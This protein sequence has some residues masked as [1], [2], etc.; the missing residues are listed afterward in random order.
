MANQELQ[1]IRFTRSGQ[2]VHFVILALIF[3]C[4]GVGLYLVSLD[5]W[6]VSQEPLLK[7]SW[8]GLL[9]LPFVIACLW[10][11]VR[12]SKHAYLIFSPVGIEIFPFFKPSTNMNVLLWNEVETVDFTEDGKMM[13]VRLL[14]EGDHQVFLSI[15]PLKSASQ[16]LL[17]HTVTGICERR[18]AAAK[19][20]EESA[21]STS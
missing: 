17:K 5:F 1:E 3:L 10:M 13:R 16:D 4:L 19:A 12:L 14:S 15:A 21:P 18:A 11:A 6:S 8:Y 2:A 7:Q 20:M 9:V